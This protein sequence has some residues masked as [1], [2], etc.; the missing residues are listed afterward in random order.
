M[1][2]AYEQI[3]EWMLK[4]HN[5]KLSQ[6][7]PISDRTPSIL[8]NTILNWLTSESYD[9]DGLKMNE[10]KVQEKFILLNQYFSKPEF[11]PFIRINSDEL[12]I[13]TMEKFNYY[14]VLI[15]LC[16]TDPGRFK[17]IYMK[18]TID[19]KLVI[20]KCKFEIKS[21]ERIYDITNDRT[22][23]NYEDMKKYLIQN[24]CYED[25]LDP[26]DLSIDM[27]RDKLFNQSQK[28]LS[29]SDNQIIHHFRKDN[30]HILLLDGELNFS[31]YTIASWSNV[32]SMMLFDTDIDTEE[33]MDGIRI[34]TTIKIFILYILYRLT[35][36]LQYTTSSNIF[37]KINHTISSKL[38][39][40]IFNSNLII[41]NCI[42]LYQFSDYLED[43]LTCTKLIDIFKEKVS[44][45]YERQ[46]F[47]DVIFSQ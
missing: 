9:D 15:S 44:D 36:F 5:R 47:Y 35:N 37:K 29:I 40:D 1:H 43:K 8:I 13:K 23:K 30:H 18:K 24:Q 38:D 21:D 46:K 31:L 33:K 34:N 10:S 26:R 27:I 12:N 42:Q 3:H 41:E 4:H 25:R 22:Y 28:S 45:R 17:Y 14:P 16:E 32:I 19:A 39:L 11:F 7:E 20:K 6:Y 2:K